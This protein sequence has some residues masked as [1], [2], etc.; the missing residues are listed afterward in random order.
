MLHVYRQNRVRIYSC[1]GLIMLC[2]GRSANQQIMSAFAV[3]SLH[4]IR[5]RQSAH[6]S[7]MRRIYTIQLDYIQ[8]GG[9]F[10]LDIRIAVWKRQH[11]CVGFGSHGWRVCV[12]L[13]S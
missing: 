8:Y 1:L 12:V 7:L 3:G 2:I 6:R 11:S 4:T 10:S 9:G 13:P 5:T